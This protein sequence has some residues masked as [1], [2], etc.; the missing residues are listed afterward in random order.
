M[1]TGLATDTFQVPHSIR[2]GVIQIR[3]DFGSG[4]YSLNVFVGRVLLYATGPT[5]DRTTNFIG[6]DYS[7]PPPVEIVVNRE[8]GGG[9]DAWSYEG[10]IVSV[11]LGYRWRKDAQ[12]VPGAYGPQYSISS[13]TLLHTG[14]YDVV[15]S[16]AVGA[17]T[18]QP[19]TL[20]LTPPVLRIEHVTIDPPQV[21]LWWISPDHMAERTLELPNGTW[22]W[23]SYP[24]SGVIL[25]ATNRQEYFRLRFSERPRD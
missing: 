1:S 17:V 10:E 13:A 9:A 14:A 3:A 18:S 22:E 7:Y 4:T 2:R 6:F 8:E 15:V 20:T 11:P 19:A 24:Y 21:Q 12:E 5:S 23:I 25:D 16:D